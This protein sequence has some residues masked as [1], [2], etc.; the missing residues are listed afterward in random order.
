[1]AIASEFPCLRRIQWN[2]AE[3]RQFR[4]NGQIPRLG[5]KFRGPWKTVGPTQDVDRDVWALA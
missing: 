4:G 2:S 5:S 1:M 3:T